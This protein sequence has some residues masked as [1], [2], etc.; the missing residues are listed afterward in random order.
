MFYRETNLA[1]GGILATNIGSEYRDS[2][3]FTSCK[4]YLDV[5]A[6]SHDDERSLGEAVEAD[7]AGALLPPRR[8][9][10]DPSRRL[11]ER[12]PGWQFKRTLSGLSFS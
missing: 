11:V 7:L 3:K 9:R 4:L 2:F 10:V 8:V 6:A 5:H 1:A 12:F